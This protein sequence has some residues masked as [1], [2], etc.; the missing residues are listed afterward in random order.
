[1]LAFAADWERD[2]ESRKVVLS[3]VSRERLDPLS[4]G[5]VF[6]LV[7]LRDGEVEYYVD[8]LS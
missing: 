1:M 6:D 3:S 4:R 7:W 8:L 5:M 2:P